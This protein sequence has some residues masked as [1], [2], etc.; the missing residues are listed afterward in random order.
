MISAEALIT[1]GRNILRNE[2][3]G[4]AV[5]LTLGLHLYVEILHRKYRARFP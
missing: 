3:T 5:H 2:E 1:N 4:Q